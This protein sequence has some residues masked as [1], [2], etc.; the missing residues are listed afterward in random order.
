MGRNSRKPRKAPDI[1]AL[2]AGTHGAKLETWVEA[3]IY[4]NPTNSAAH[5]AELHQ[6]YA[7][8]SRLQSRLIL[9]H[10]HALK[11]KG[12][13]S[14]W[15]LRPRYGGRDAC[16]ILLDELDP[17]ARAWAQRQID[18]DS[19]ETET[20]AAVP[21]ST[22]AA[23]LG[24]LEQG[25]EALEAYDYDLALDCFRSALSGDRRTEASVALLETF[26]DHLGMNEEALTFGAQLS[27]ELS[28]N[29]TIRGLLGLAAARRGD[30]G[31]AERWIKGLRIPRAADTVAEL[32]RAELSRQNIE[33]ASL[34]LNVLSQID[35]SYYE[36]SSLG[37]QID[38]LKAEQCER[39][40]LRLREALAKNDDSIEAIAD[41]VLKSWPES[42]LARETLQQRSST[43]DVEAAQQASVKGDAAQ[44]REDYDGAILYYT[45]AARID[46]SK[47]NA[48][49]IA[50]K[51][52]AVEYAWQAAK[53]GIL[54]LVSGPTT[55]LLQAFLRLAPDH[56]ARIPMPD[57]SLDE[58]VRWILECAQEAVQTKASR[59][60]ALGP[61]LS[62]L[63]EARNDVRT[64]DI[65]KAQ[66]LLETHDRI[67]SRIPKASLLLR[68]IQSQQITLRRRTIKEALSAAKSAVALGH[69]DELATQLALLNGGG[70][71][72]EDKEVLDGLRIELDR[73]RYERRTVQTAEAYLNSG[74]FAHATISLR[75]LLN[76]RESNAGAL[77]NL[78]QVTK[79]LAHATKK[80]E[81]QWRIV[82]YNFS[83][84]QAATVHVG[85]N[86]MLE[87]SQPWTS[88]EGH[89]FVADNTGPSITLFEFEAAPL[90]L[91][92]A[93]QLTVPM[94]D[95][96]EDFA[97]L[98]RLRIQ[99]NTAWLWRSD[100]YVL[101]IRLSDLVITTWH[102]PAD[103]EAL[104]KKDLRYL[105]RD[106]RFAWFSG[107][108]GKDLVFDLNNQRVHRTVEGSVFYAEV[109][110][111]AEEVVFSIDAWD[112]ARLSRPNGS[113]W[114]DYDLDG[115]PVR[116]LAKGF[117]SNQW[118]A[119]APIPDAADNESN[120][121]LL[122]LGVN[123]EIYN[124]IRIENGDSDLISVLTRGTNPARAYV[125]H[126][127][128]DG[129]R[130]LTSYD[131]RL[132]NAE[133]TQVPRTAALIDCGEDQSPWLLYPG[134]GGL[135]ACSTAQMGPI[136][137]ECLEDGARSR[138]GSCHYKG[139]LPG[140]E[141]HGKILADLPTSRIDHYVG[142]VL[143]TANVQEILGLQDALGYFDPSGAR[144]ARVEDALQEEFE[145]H[146]LLTVAIAFRMARRE[147]WAQAR[148]LLS[149]M[150]LAAVPDSDRQHALHLLALTD[151][152]DNKY[153][154]AFGY[155]DQAR[156]LDGDCDLG[157]IEELLNPLPD[158][159]PE[160]W[161]EADPFAYRQIARLGRAATD[162]LKAGKAQDA[163][164]VIDRPVVWTNP[165]PLSAA[166]LAV[167]YIRSNDGTQL[168][169]LQARRTAYRLIYMD[170][171]NTA[172]TIL[173]H[174]LG[175]EVAQ[176]MRQEVESWLEQLQS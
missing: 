63:S 71:S 34:R 32:L 101:G 106:G 159:D 133:P 2:L 69:Q 121:E 152:L 58:P 171:Y 49:L 20:T 118:L 115:L 36:L 117:E 72:A 87:A 8:K 55:P 130:W 88:C 95:L 143:E 56:Q 116:S 103:P 142:E 147:D 165:E 155:L 26:V 48:R 131:P 53:E 139:P 7:Q 46:P 89:I 108:E 75:D 104:G 30:V 85:L 39:A 4:I 91:R 166:I 6:R 17:D 28:L 24:H 137:P 82:R 14:G 22:S 113:A 141:A 15:I 50:A 10:G 134:A 157:D 120:L 158:P 33:Q 156:A 99:A 52:Q 81:E 167:S 11:L 144:R 161:V 65:D 100:G 164:K 175:A 96:D 21:D 1:E 79:R 78:S 84:N 151:A 42:R 105:S 162:L 12:D 60:E 29:E 19:E 43:R 136:P 3:I 109:P 174:I 83:E 86:A 40:E 127:N 47:Y 23:P 44:A 97:P 150:D 18:S 102:I 123:G 80:L 38:A 107:T 160:P 16:H 73:M 61:V 13:P 37:Q 74:D 140:S 128:V 59:K 145:D 132:E 114:R 125:L 172:N 169:R 70:L 146:P 163:L 27:Q 173:L 66:A 90:R 138:P 77:N 94:R 98:E 41:E 25:F 57:W 129:E 93:I 51:H 111:L 176:E 153:E 9:E 168:W 170:E 54:S 5:G 67:I 68:E 110:G 76:S 112:Q 124:S 64:G 119:L 62:A 45:A 126:D 31:A 92:R 148:E 35:A 154:S 149:K 135:S 122:G